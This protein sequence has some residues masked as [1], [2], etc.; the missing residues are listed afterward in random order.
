MHSSTRRYYSQHSAAASQP[1]G[2]LPLLAITFH[3]FDDDDDDDDDGGDDDDAGL[4]PTSCNHLPPLRGAAQR[5]Q[6]RALLLQ[7][8]RCFLWQRL[9][10]RGWRWW[11]WEGRDGWFEIP[12]LEGLKHRR[13][14][15]L[16]QRALAII[17]QLW[18]CFLMKMRI[19][20]DSTSEDAGLLASS[21]NWLVDQWERPR[22]LKQTILSFDFTGHCPV[23]NRRYMAKPTIQEGS[24]VTVYCLLSLLGAPRLGAPTSISTMTCNFSSLIFNLDVFQVLPSTTP[25]SAWLQLSSLLGN[26]TT[27]WLASLLCYLNHLDVT[28]A[29]EANAWLP[30]DS[31]SLNSLFWFYLN[32][33]WQFHSINNLLFTCCIAFTASLMVRWTL[34]NVPRD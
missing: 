32:M 24:L 6:K 27:R 12:R 23:L 33:N 21:D 18:C 26:L 16:W 9:W 11:S 19:E 29:A 34:A 1:A 31:V 28:L 8:F 20:K 7:N 14:L 30:S 15:K 22:L 3:S 5:N 25:T 2:P 4:L 13:L 10:E 17:D